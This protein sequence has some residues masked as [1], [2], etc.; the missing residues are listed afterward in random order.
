MKESDN[1]IQ[2]RLRQVFDA[3]GIS[4]YQIAK[5]LNENSSKFYNILSGR[6][7]PSY[8]TIIGILNYYPQVRADFLL[9]GEGAVLTDDTLSNAFLSPETSYVEVPYVPIKFH[10]SFVE[11][12]TDSYR[13]QDLE[14]FR[15][16]KDLVKNLRE[17][18]IIE[19]SGNSMSPQLVPGA[20]VL[21]VPVDTGDWIYLSGG[22]FAVI[23]RDFFVVKRI[24]EN[25][26]LTKRYLT[27]HSDNPMGGSVTVPAN[28][29]RGIWRVANIVSAPV[30]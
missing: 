26:L 12:Y 13:F 2:E 5:D 17:P 24:R 21:A 1:S 7:K 10:A 28:E 29:I 18:V 25:D 3:L 27:L 23:Y 4:I 8:D 16:S 15:I 30:E 11:S 19:I 9:R 22:V 14:T 20:R 6:A